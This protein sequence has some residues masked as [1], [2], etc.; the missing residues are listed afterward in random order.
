MASVDAQQWLEQW[1]EENLS[2]PG[3]VEKK[4]EMRDRAA[5]CARDSQAAG[6]SI[7]D[8]KAAADDDLEAY[9]VQRQNALTDRKEDG[10][11]D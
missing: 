8:L 6:I 3:H 7:H 9:L 11:G 1:V 2:E 10:L 5:A 4:S